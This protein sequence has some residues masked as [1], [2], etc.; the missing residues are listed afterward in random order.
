MCGFTRFYNCWTFE[1]S[2]PS[3][4]LH[5][6]NGKVSRILSNTNIPNIN[7]NRF[8]EKSTYKL[9]IT[10]WINITC[11]SI[12]DKKHERSSIR[13]V[14]MVISPFGWLIRIVGSFSVAQ[15]KQ[16]MLFALDDARAGLMLPFHHQSRLVASDCPCQSLNRYFKIKLYDKQF[17][18]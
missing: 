7:N 2:Y 15:M 4:L 3:L 10:E 13:S 17:Q 1:R 9:K 5:K 12:D 16:P 6:N 18:L 14:N 11:R 8:V